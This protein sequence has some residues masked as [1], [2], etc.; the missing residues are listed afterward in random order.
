MMTVAGVPIP[1]STASNSIVPNSQIQELRE[2][3]YLLKQEQKSLKVPIA[4]AP[5]VHDCQN[6]TKATKRFR[7]IFEEDKEE[8]TKEES[9]MAQIPSSSSLPL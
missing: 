9:K 6:L 3:N 4:P 1:H 7:P 5:P 2:I 8:E